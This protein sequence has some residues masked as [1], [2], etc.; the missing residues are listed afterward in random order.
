MHPNE[1]VLPSRG[2]RSARRMYGDPNWFMNNKNSAL[3]G[4]RKESMV[5][6]EYSRVD[7]PEVTLDAPNFL[8]KN[9]MPEPCLEFA[10]SK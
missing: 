1:T 5:Y 10:L 9:F 4:G 6:A 8:F 7:R 3:H 2:V